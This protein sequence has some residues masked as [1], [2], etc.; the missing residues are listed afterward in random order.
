MSGGILGGGG[1]PKL[2]FSHLEKTDAVAQKDVGSAATSRDSADGV[3]PATPAAA[4]APA[5]APA[6]ANISQVGVQTQAR[7]GRA[8]RK[9]P[10]V[11]GTGSGN[12][13]LGQ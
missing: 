1:V 2:D 13:L 12:S 8:K 6:P 11:G 4:P 9:K 10:G 7:S 3:I 5:E